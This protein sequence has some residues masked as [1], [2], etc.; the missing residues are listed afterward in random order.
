MSASRIGE[1]SGAGSASVRASA[2][3]DG[4]DHDDDIGDDE[5]DRGDGD[6]NDEDDEDDEDEEDRWSR[7]LFSPVR[8]PDDVPDKLPEGVVDD[9]DVDA[10]D[11]SREEIAYLMQKA[12]REGGEPEPYR[13]QLENE[14]LHGLRP[15]TAR[16]AHSLQ[17]TLGAR[18]RAMAD[19]RLDEFQ[20]EADLVVR[21]LKGE[22]VLFEDEAQ[23]TRVLR[24]A[25]EFL[26]AKK[27]R[28]EKEREE[29][30]REEKEMAKDEQGGQQAQV[31]AQG[32][33]EEGTRQDVDGDGL[34]GSSAPE[35]PPAEPWYPVKFQPIDEETQMAFIKKYVQG[36]YYGS[37]RE[38]ARTTQQSGR[39]GAA[40]VA[41]HQLR[42]GLWDRLNSTLASNETMPPEE[43]MAV[44]EKVRSVLMLTTQAAAAA[45]TAPPRKSKRR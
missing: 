4:D 41:A 38:P 35:P 7:K 34:P 10:D 15:L 3:T 5:D 39:P 11:L 6:G 33:K 20:H 29:R 37:G 30:E 16:D 42:E 43:Q 9:V 25:D 26:Y 8:V 40:P 24:E 17:E 2:D 44:L 32:Q 18:L 19:V 21:F 45:K 31:Q 12:A 1:A 13:P 22:L 14:S 28:K 36:F 23:K 27:E